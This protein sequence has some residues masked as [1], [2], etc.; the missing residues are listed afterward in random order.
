MAD[1][2]EKLHVFIQELWESTSSSHGHLGD[3]NIAHAFDKK[4]CL[5][6]YGITSADLYTQ[7]FFTLVIAHFSP[8]LN[9]GSKH[10]IE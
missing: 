6:T 10:L 1:D 7:E 5:L 2:A 4:Q 3:F 8:P 9:L